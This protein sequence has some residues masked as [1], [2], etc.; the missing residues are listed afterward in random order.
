MKHLVILLLSVCCSVIFAQ[1]IDQRK[2]IQS[3]MNKEDSVKSAT[4]VRNYAND[5]SK[6]IDAYLKKHPKTVKTYV[7]N[8]KLYVLYDIS[9]EGNPIYITTKKNKTPNK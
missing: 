7:K 4:L 8:K 2:S 9:K 6:R 5:K 3:S 1:T